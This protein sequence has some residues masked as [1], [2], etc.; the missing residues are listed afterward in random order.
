MREATLLDKIIAHGGVMSI[1]LFF[2]VCCLFFSLTTGAFLTAPNLLNIVRQ[3]A[4]LLIVAAAMTFVI[5]TGGID[6]SVGSVLA[7]TATLSAA[8]LQAGIPWPLTILL[9]LALGA[10]VG[11]IQ[12]YFIAYERIPAF[13]VTLAGLSIIRGVAL[14]I[15]GGYSIPIEPASPFVA[16]GRAWVFGIPAPAL[17]AI[18]VLAVAYLA[19]NETP[20]GRYVT[21]VGANNEA[22]RRAGVD[23]RRVVLWV[24][25][26]SGM[27]AASAGI[28]L[29]ARLGSGSSN[30]GQGFELD[31]IAAVVL[32]GTSLFG[33]RGS[34]VGTILGALTVAVL[35]NGLILSHLSPFFTPIVTGFIILVAIWLNFRLFKGGARGR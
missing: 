12:G 8:A 35:A 10:V 32:G 31:V 13:I 28:I 11:I 27:A 29:A 20:F 15:T 23:T 16:I 17:I 34:L 22:T 1:A 33:G 18:I 24:Y 5:T 26:L 9:M 2:I 7:L 4:P 14:L 21:G 19:F 25:V 30:A 6:L 3:S